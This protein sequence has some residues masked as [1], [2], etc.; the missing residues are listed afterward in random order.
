M[1]PLYK[2]LCDELKVAPDAAQLKKMSDSNATR[3]KEIEAEITDA[4]ANLGMFSLLLE[5]V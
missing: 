2:I 5:V 4:E 1:A 3:V